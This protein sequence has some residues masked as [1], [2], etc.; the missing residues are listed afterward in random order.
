MSTLVFN[1]SFIFSILYLR[2][3]LFITTDFTFSSVF[4]TNWD[5]VHLVEKFLIIFS[6]YVY[7]PY[8]SNGLFFYV[9]FYLS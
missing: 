7:V 1:L 3:S 5:V 4:S 9:S 2:S 6:H 8:G